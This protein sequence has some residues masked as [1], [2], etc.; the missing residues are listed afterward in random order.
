M[1]RLIRSTATLATLGAATLAYGGLVE[2]NAFTLPRFQV[3][4]LTPGAPPLRVL[5][6]SDLH[7]TPGQKRK[8]AWI[9]DLA[10]LAPDLVIN[11]GDTI[12]NENA[13]PA[14]M[15]ALGPLLDFPGAFV[16]GN[17]DYY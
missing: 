7:I 17:N 15:R 4:V 11:T 10:R 6:I 8:I 14:I 13:I 12:S 1:G 2:R 9:A 3:P 16:P 5:H